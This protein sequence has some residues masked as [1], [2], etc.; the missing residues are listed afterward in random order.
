VVVVVVVIM[1]VVMIV[2]FIVICSHANLARIA[3]FRG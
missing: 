3:S 1:V 2:I